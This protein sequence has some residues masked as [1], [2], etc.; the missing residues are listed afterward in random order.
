MIYLS[1]SNGQKMLILEPQ[2]L[3]R[4]KEGKEAASPEGMMG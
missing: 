2:N 1:L 3:E 4:L